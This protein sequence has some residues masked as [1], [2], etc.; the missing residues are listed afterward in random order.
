MNSSAARRTLL[1]LLLTLDR[2]GG[3]GPRRIAKPAA[4]DRSRLISSPRSSSSISRR[5]RSRLHAGAARLAVA[6]ADPRVGTREAGAG[7]RTAAWPRGVCAFGVWY[8]GKTPQRA[9]KDVASS[10]WLMEILPVAR[11]GGPR[12]LGLD[13]RLARYSGMNGSRRRRRSTTRR[14]GPRSTTVSRADV[15]LLRG[16]PCAPLRAVRDGAAGVHAPNARARHF[17]APAP[18]RSMDRRFGNWS[19]P[20]AVDGHGPLLTVARWQ[21]QVLA[22]TSDLGGGRF[23]RIDRGGLRDG[24]DEFGVSAAL[25]TAK[26][27]AHLYVFHAMCDVDVADVRLV[28]VMVRRSRR[29][30]LNR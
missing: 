26:D 19:A 24:R 10:P 7:G 22:A 21:P 20:A 4:A 29:V 27:G 25:A 8:Y 1:F 16:A 14:F 12:A 2:G 13:P 23:V 17:E 15:V 18:P 11:S 28:D 3:R 9:I 5:R 6:N 30:D